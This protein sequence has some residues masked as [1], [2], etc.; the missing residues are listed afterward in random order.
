[1][2]GASI[3]C[4]APMATAHPE[5][6][7]EFS[8]FGSRGLKVRVT[9]TRSVEGTIAYWTR[10]VEHVARDQPK[11]L[12]VLD[13]LTGTELTPAQWHDLVEAM[14]GKGLEQVR[15][16]HVKLYGLDHVDYCELYANI[17]GFDA[18]AFN[19]QGDAERWLR[20]GNVEDTKPP[21]FEWA[22]D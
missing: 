13:E 7:S 11:C 12:L 16:A 9:G 21:S 14:E 19:N 18:R 5:V 20:Y 10:I 4:A 15:I 2:F 6:S 8:R 1:M 17:A 22:R 3:P